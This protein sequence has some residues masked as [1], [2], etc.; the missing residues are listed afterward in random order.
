MQ[1]PNTVKYDALTGM[2]AIAAIMVFVYH[3]RKY[4][5]NDL[6][7]V[8]MRFIS[9]WH[10]GV[11]VFF[12][13]SGFLLAYRYQDKPLE[14]KKDYLKYI[15]LR[16]ARIF[17]LYWI[18][19]SFY[20]LDTEYS[21]NV[22]TYFLQYSLLYSLFDGY[23]LTGI[24]Q[25]WSLNVEF[26]FYLLSPVLFLLLKKSWKYCVSLMLG[27]FLL[28]CA[29][30]Y[31]LH[32]YNANPKGFFYPLNFIMSNT[33]FGRSTEFF[34]GMLLAYI[35]KQENKVNTL[36]KLKNPTLYGG[37]LML[38]FTIA[39]AFFARN[40]FVHGVERWEGRLIHELFLPVGIALFFWGLMS[41][42]TWIS[43]F[44]STKFLILL[45]NASFVFYLIHI[46]YFNL[47]LKSY[48]Y[49]PDRNFILLWICSIIIYLWIEKPLYKLCRNLIAKISNFPQ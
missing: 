40:N 37:L 39:I 2:R 15:L 33:F 22:D 31:G 21:K 26:F 27:L 7:W 45:G 9:E 18:L 4:W 5:R 3:N 8:V 14:S 11:T 20:F 42:K 49:L 44:L 10:I 29:I 28:S 34:F 13:L 32:W 30:G 35:M 36:L 46:S 1:S 25:A 17:P 16:I 23:V 38:L 41:E 19:L 12:V 6:P 47:K 24:V 43:R 48:L